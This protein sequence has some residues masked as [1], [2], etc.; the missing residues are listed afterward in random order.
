MAGKIILV[1]IVSFIAFKINAM[2]GILIFIVLFV[3]L[4]YKEAV[5][6]QRK[7][8]DEIVSNTYKIRE[9]RQEIIKNNTAIT[10]EISGNDGK[11]SVVL[12]ENSNVI[13]LIEG[14]QKRKISY[15]DLLQSEII[16]DGVQVTSTSRASQ[17]GGA[18]IGAVVA[19]GIG[20]IIGGLSG[21]QETTKKVKK[22]DLKLT[23]NDTKNPIFTINF[24]D[25]G[26]VTVTKDNPN[27]REAIE[28][29]NHWHNL[30]SVLIRRA[31]EEER[32]IQ[33]Q[34]I[35]KITQGTTTSIADEL[36]KLSNLL[37]EGII[38]QEEFNQQKAKI[39]S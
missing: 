39:M 13:Y 3:G 25:I 18:L 32:K 28:K 38:T 35:Q 9:T 29:A 37:K 34:S 36:L 17:I 24:F 12:D 8:K 19:G 2:L 10:S 30:M 6:E 26:D 5:R 4:A 16:E 11:S 7:K 20:A 33:N 27:Y 21:K 23:I 1:A 15:K 14:Y 22:I 31:D